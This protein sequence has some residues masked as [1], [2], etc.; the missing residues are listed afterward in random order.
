MDSSYFVHAYHFLN[1]KRSE[2]SVLGGYI[3]VGNTNFNI[4]YLFPFLLLHHLKSVLKR[5]FVISCSVF[6]S[7]TRL[8]LRSGIHICITFIDLIIHVYS[9]C[10][11]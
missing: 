1:I 6:L 8:A 9:H 11:R 5:C 10:Q 4:S 2:E 3:L 7:L